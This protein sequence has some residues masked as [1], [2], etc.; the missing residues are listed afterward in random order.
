MNNFI[1]LIL[2]TTLQWF[3]IL[4]AIFLANSI[5]KANAEWYWLIHIFGS[6]YCLNTI[7]KENKF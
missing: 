3:T 7:F 4:S 1:F 2:K 6:L 5:F